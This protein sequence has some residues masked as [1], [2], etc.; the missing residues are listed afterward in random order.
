MA[1][2]GRI[3][4][5]ETTR[6]QVRLIFGEPDLSTEVRQGVEEFTYLEGKNA[7]ESWLVLSGYLLYHPTE[8]FSSDTILLIR[9]KDDKVARFI[10]SDGHTTLKKGY[11]E[12]KKEPPEEGQEEGTGEKQEEGTN[13]S[14]NE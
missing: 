12:D 5:G 8:A 4:P 13:P 11:K 7:V 14:E 9:F 2:I 6:D 1:K 10:A 3:T